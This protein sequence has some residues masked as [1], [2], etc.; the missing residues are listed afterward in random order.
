MFR[1]IL[2][3]F[4]LIHFQVFGNDALSELKARLQQDPTN[5]IVLS[6]YIL[7]LQEAQQN[8]EAH[9]LAK[10]YF[11]KIQENELAAPE[12]W[13]VV[14]TFVVDMNQQ[15][16]ERIAKNSAAFQQN[17]GQFFT[18]YLADLIEK[19]LVGVQKIDQLNGLKKYYFQILENNHENAFEKKY[20]DQFLELY[21]YKIRQDWTSYLPLMIVWT[22]K[23][24]TENWYE[25]FRKACEL[26]EFGTDYL[27]KAHQWAKK[28]LELHP[29]DLTFYLYAKILVKENHHQE[30]KKYLQKAK[31]MA[32]EAQTLELIDE[33]AQQI[34]SY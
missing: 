30:A 23:Y 29:A 15:E 11:E 21:F 6:E 24:H 18:D 16:F 9:E 12:N 7:A 5:K 3:L 27:E 4:L 14:S 22:E 28:S 2:M 1:N 34:S 19:Q 25:L 20:Y 10:E 31:E 32:S 13:V 8:Q 33:L 17:L 26:S